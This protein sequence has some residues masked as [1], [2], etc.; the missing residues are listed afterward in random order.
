ML[1]KGSRK[2]ALDQVRPYFSQDTFLTSLEPISRVSYLE[3]E[4]AEIPARGTSCWRGNYST[5]D[6][7][8]K[9]ECSLDATSAPEEIGVAQPLRI[10]SRVAVAQQCCPILR[11]HPVPDGN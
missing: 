5:S 10:Q 8:S 1:P 11:L 6:R 4:L 7:G 3:T 2:L 9:V